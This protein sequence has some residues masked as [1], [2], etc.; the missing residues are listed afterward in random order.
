MENAYPEATVA[1]IDLPS[2]CCKKHNL[3]ELL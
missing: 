3:F 1:I 2:I